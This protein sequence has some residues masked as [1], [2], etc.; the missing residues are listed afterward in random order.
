LLALLKDTEWF[1]NLGVD[2]RSERKE[3]EGVREKYT[4]IHAHKA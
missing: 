1:E 2:A 4:Y 3:M